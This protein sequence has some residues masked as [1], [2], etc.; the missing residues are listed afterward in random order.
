MHVGDLWNYFPSID[1]L[2]GKFVRGRTTRGEVADELGSPTGWGAAVLPPAHRAQDVMFFQEIELGD[3]KG[4]GG[5]IL[6]NVEQKI[7]I[8]FLS[9]GVF[10]GYMWFSSLPETLG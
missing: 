5:E 4:V 6:V 3:M 8:V 2:E 7:L 1:A 9:G 10:D